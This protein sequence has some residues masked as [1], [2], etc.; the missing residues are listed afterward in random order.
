LRLM[1]V[2]AEQGASAFLFMFV[3][4]GLLLLNI[5]G[6]ILAFAFISALLIEIL[7][8]LKDLKEQLNKVTPSCLKVKE[9][10]ER[11]LKEKQIN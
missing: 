7:I 5:I 9:A 1:L 10:V 3:G 2:G 4:Y 8:Q 11:Y 6:G